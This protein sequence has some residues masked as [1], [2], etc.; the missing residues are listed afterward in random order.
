VTVIPAGAASAGGRRS[1]LFGPKP[2]PALP[3][4]KLRYCS[5]V[6]RLRSAARGP[7]I[8]VGDECCDTAFL[9]YAFSCLPAP[10][11]DCPR[12]TVKARPEMVAQAVRKNGREE[13]TPSGI[14]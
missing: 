5:G 12:K 3:G 9:L 13:T 8:G 10:S 2:M 1:W 7:H 4:V 11:I 6:T 14:F